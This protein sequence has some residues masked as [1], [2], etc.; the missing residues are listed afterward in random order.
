VSASGP[1]EDARVETVDVTVDPTAAGGRIDRFLGNRFYPTYS[2]S[3]LTGLIESG[4]ITVNGATVRPAYRVAP[5]DVIRARLA[6]RTEVSPA[7]EDL[8]L[9]V[10]FEDDL[11]VVVNKPAGMIVHP[12]PKTKSGTL[13]NALLRRFPEIARVGVVFRPGIVHR[14]DG[15]TSGVMVVARTNP[16][17]VH[18]VDQFKS[19]RVEKEYR[20][21]V[22]GTM[23][24]DRDYIDLPLGPDPGKP[25][26]QRV[27]MDEGKPSSTFYEVIERYPGATLVRCV[28]HTGRT[29]QIRVHLAH[30]G[31]PVVADPMYGAN[32]QQ[33]YKNLRRNRMEKGLPYPD[34]QRHSLHA[35]RLAIDHPVTGERM[36]FEAPL[37]D[38]MAKLVEFYRAYARE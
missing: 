27:D 10:L 28:P 6:P 29:H 12:G 26:R 15:N 30:V 7:P 14:L 17:R 22:V 38:D 25:D 18:L 23:P 8:P 20:A 2:R 24:F 37:P 19:K 36:A 32:K 21:V 9:E 1:A 31:F 16:A 5:G 34:I 35:F 11:I 4:D 3:F 33:A 13:V